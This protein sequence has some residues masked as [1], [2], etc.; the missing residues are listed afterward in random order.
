MPEDEGREFEPDTLRIF[1]AG[2]RA[3]DKGY[4]EDHVAFDRDRHDRDGKNKRLLTEATYGWRSPAINH[5]ARS[6]RT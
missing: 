6:G 5:K 2:H 1:E 4:F 3:E